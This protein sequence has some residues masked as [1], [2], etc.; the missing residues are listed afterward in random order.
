MGT[1]VSCIHI[2]TLSQLEGEDPPTFSRI[3]CMGGN[4]S[5]KRLAPSGNRSVGDTRI[6]HS[7]YLLPREFVDQYANEVKSRQR[8]P[9]GK[10]VARTSNQSDSEDDDNNEEDDEVTQDPS[11][12]GA[13]DPTDGTSAAP[14][15]CASNWKAASAEEHKRMWSIFDE[16]GVFLTACR[17]GLILWIAD[18][19]R[20]GE[21]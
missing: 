2:L 7:D 20:S 21:L 14:T 11:M 6:F 8:Q 1:S 3:I 12:A 16:T 17:H 5:L 18:M 19:V 13:G 9:K 4:N 10:A 15:P